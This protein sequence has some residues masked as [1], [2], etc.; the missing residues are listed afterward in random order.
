MWL[1][2]RHLGAV[3]ERRGDALMD[4]FKFHH[5]VVHAPKVQKLSPTMFKHWVNVLCLASANTPRGR[6]P[7][8]CDVAWHLKIAE[9]RAAVLLDELLAMRLLDEDGQ[10]N[11]TPHN[12]KLRQAGKEGHDPDE[13][14][15]AGVRGNHVRWHVNA[16]KPDAGCSLCVS[17]GLAVAIAKPSLSD[18]LIHREESREEEDQSRAEGERDALAS[19][20]NKAVEFHPTTAPPWP[21]DVVDDTSFES[22]YV[23]A[24]RKREHRDHPGASVTAEC[25]RLE[26]DFGRDACVEIAADHNWEKHPNWL[27]PKLEQRAKDAAVVAEAE[28]VTARSRRY[29]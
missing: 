6:V 12:W 3:P 10:G 4:W 7:P 18:S 19:P 27:R 25:R 2:R 24:Y 23:L 14:A 11:L 15:D 26:R 13:R 16:H 28:P 9:G 29:A 20:V 21:D 8:P 17:E 5:D 1:R 22:L